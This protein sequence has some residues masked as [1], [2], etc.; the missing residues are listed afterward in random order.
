MQWLQS[1]LDWFTS[2]E[3]W[4]ITS[5]AIIPFVAIVLAGVIGALAARGAIRRLIAQRDRETRV[6]AVTALVTAGQQA[7][8]WSSLSPAAKDHSDDLASRADIE[9]R[10][11][12][13]P[14][15]ELAADWAAHQIGVMRTHSVS[16]SFPAEES[17]SDFV[18]RLADPGP[19]LSAQA[20]EQ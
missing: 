8:K 9:V 13:A 18:E 2:F 15:S 16:Y 1:I 20:R 19:G 14:G 10:L 6:A 11:L 5:G 17:V 7:A 12:P 3:G 4:R